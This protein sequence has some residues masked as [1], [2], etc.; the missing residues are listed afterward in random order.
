MRRAVLSST[1]GVCEGMS[2]VS[3]GMASKLH[4]RWG[5]TARKEALQ[6][7]DP[8]LQGEE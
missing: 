4:G 8:Q 6:S 1:Q 3:K 2:V 5:V 7:V